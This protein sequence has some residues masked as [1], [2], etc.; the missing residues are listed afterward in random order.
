[1]ELR[2][3]GGAGI[4][5]GL[6]SVAGAGS[7]RFFF[8]PPNTFNNRVARKNAERQGVEEESGFFLLF[9]I[10]YRRYSPARID[11]AP[12]RRTSFFIFFFFLVSLFFATL[13][14]LKEKPALLGFFR[15]LL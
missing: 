3:A 8:L 5:E 9:T 15:S 14:A 10:Y 12:P 4:K 2:E 6:V 11:P 13:L 7:I 1:M